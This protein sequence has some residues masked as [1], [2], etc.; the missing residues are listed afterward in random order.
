LKENGAEFP[1]EKGM[2]IS[3]EELV[4]KLKELKDIFDKIMEKNGQECVEEVTLLKESVPLFCQELKG[5]THRNRA[6]SHF[7]LSFFYDSY[8]TT[9]NGLTFLNSFSLFSPSSSSFGDSRPHCSG[10]T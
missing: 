7:V 1:E 9:A 6:A 8:T 5:K 10:R 2:V 4:R 3:H